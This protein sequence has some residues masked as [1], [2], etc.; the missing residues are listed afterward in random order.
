MVDVVL[1]GMRVLYR[2][3]KDEG[4]ESMP[5]LPFRKDVVNSIFLKY[6]ADHYRAV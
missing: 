4:N 3:N 1:K 2:I 6:W 5:L